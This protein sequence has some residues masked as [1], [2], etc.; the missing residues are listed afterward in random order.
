MQEQTSTRTK[1]GTYCLF[2][3]IALPFQPFLSLRG[4]I[5]AS[6]KQPC[7]FRLRLTWVFAA[8]QN[9]TSAISLGEKVS[10]G[11]T[12]VKPNN[13]VE[14]WEEKRTVAKISLTSASHFLEWNVQR[15]LGS[16]VGQH[17]E[18][19]GR[20]TLCKATV[21]L[22]R[23]AEQ[24]RVSAAGKGHVRQ[25][26]LDAGRPAAGAGQHRNGTET[27]HGD[28]LETLQACSVHPLEQTLPQG[29]DALPRRLGGGF[30]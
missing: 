15:S 19:Y 2:S 25:R 6:H 14:D 13:K 1:V 21:F 12:K 22:P 29:E 4:C 18:C 16:P 11:W 10:Q 20:S 8:L 24:R 7:S 26:Q 9:F 17:S 27:G 3:L 30:P 23:R 28:T 5:K